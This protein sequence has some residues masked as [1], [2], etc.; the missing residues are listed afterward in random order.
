MGSRSAHRDRRPLRRQ[1]RPEIKTCRDAGDRSR[2]KGVARRANALTTLP[3]P[4][5]SPARW[6]GQGESGRPPARSRTPASGRN[7]ARRRLVRSLAR[8]DRAR[9]GASSGVCWGTLIRLTPGGAG[10]W[11]R[12]GAAA[13]RSPAA[14]LLMLLTSDTVTRAAAMP[15]GPK[16]ECA[17]APPGLLRVVCSD[18][19]L[20]VCVDTRVFA[21][22]WVAS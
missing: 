10:F 11:N 6:R 22:R 9:S 2:G 14:R 18:C 5:Q 1:A 7:Q 21:L 4:R 8:P 12:S 3:S 17:A 15:N 13:S 19:A 20:D 16:Q